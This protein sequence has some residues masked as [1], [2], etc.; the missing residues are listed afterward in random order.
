MTVNERIAATV[1]YAEY[2]C[3]K[4]D[5]IVPV[6]QGYELAEYEQCWRLLSS[7]I[8][9]KRLALG[10]VC[11]RQSTKDIAVLCWGLMQFLPPV[12]VHGFGV[13]FR[14]L[15]WPECWAFFSSI[16]TNSWEYHAR[17]KN[18][19]DAEAWAIYDGMF[20]DVAAAPRQLLLT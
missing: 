3:H 20:K 17:R 6:L 13:K 10:S 15:R 2:L 9:V 11:Q 7:K 12:P 14:A 19:K 5:L 4:S 8:D 1:E 18:L 16:D